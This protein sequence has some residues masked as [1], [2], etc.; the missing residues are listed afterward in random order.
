MVSNESSLVERIGDG[1]LE[2]KL[3][4]YVCEVTLYSKV[5]SLELDVSNTGVWPVSRKKCGRKLA[6]EGFKKKMLSLT[7]C[8]LVSSAKTV[9]DEL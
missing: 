6:T 8:T 2:C 5:D 3:S 7:T 4:V 9:F 1:F